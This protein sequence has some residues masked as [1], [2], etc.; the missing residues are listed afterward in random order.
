MVFIGSD[1]GWAAVVVSLKG[2]A[3]GTAAAHKLPVGTKKTTVHVLE[4][5]AKD[6]AVTNKMDPIQAG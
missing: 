1:T 3:S 6:T 5:K 2:V 4:V